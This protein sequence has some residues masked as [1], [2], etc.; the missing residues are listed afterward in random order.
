MLLMEYASVLSL[1]HP[2]E[3]QLA[4]YKF[5]CQQSSIIYVRALYY[6]VHPFV[7]IKQ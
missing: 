2:N 6:Y 1:L 3:Q 5:H 7:H 4:S